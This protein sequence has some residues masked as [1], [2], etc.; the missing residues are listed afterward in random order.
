[1]KI[2]EKSVIMPYKQGVTGSTPVSPTKYIPLRWVFLCIITTFYIPKSSTNSR[3][4][5]KA[6]LIGDWQ[7][8]T[9]AKQILQEL[10]C[11]GLLCILK[12]MAPELKPAKEK[13]ILKR[14][15]AEH[16]SNY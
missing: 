16:T 11:L 14:E 5:V 3:S 1:V 7:S 6:I 8:I 2:T 9:V 13:T 12:N 10:E 4:G 15:K